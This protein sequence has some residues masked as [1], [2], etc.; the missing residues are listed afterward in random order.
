ML[1]GWSEGRHSGMNGCCV[2][3]GPFRVSRLQ[4]A[5]K[6]MACRKCGSNLCTFNRNQVPS[7]V[8]SY[9]LLTSDERIVPSDAQVILAAWTV[10]FESHKCIVSERTCAAVCYAEGSTAS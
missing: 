3:G 5:A 9:V 4:R 2:A 8:S 10:W 1:K 6:Y 7:M